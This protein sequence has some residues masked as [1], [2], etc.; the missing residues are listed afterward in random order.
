[1]KAKADLE[2]TDAFA[3]EMA[4]RRTEVSRTA[5]FG[6]KVSWQQIGCVDLGCLRA[7]RPSLCPQ[8]ASR[9]SLGGQ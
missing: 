6:N 3:R 7:H 8:R 2:V 5:A 9:R 1:M 4:V